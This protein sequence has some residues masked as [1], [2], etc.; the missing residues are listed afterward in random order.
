MKETVNRSTLLLTELILDLFLFAVCAVV[1]AGLLLRAHGISE[2]SARLARAV[3]LAETAAE[4]FRAGGAGDTAV[5]EGD[6][7]VTV[8]D[9]S[10]NGLRTAEIT[11]AAQ[12][13][14]VLYTIT[15]SRAQEVNAP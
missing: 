1:C 13:G 5:R 3:Y 4:T 2:E 10:E 15:A 11:V 12:D 6:L 9:C 14:R 8:D 7:V